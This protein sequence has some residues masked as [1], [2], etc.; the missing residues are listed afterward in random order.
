MNNL[1]VIDFFCGAG[2]FSEGFRQQGFK[3]I[4]GY[5][6][7]KPAIETFN[8]NFD[9]DSE[10]KNILDFQYSIE[11]I[12]K[13]PDTDV[14]IG[15]PP[16]VTFSSSNI[17]G[18]ADKSTGITLTQIFLKIVALKKWK[19]NSKLKAWFMENVPSSI[20]HLGL[21][22]TFED[23]GLAEWAAKNKIGKT[24][25]AIKLE[26]NQLIV[27]SADYG[28]P[29]SRKRAISGEIIK[30]KK[31]IIP[32]KTHGKN[33][34]SKK[35]WVTVEEIKNRIP[36][37]FSKQKSNI[38]QDPSYL[39]L[40]LDQSLLTD[41]Y[42]DTGLYQC[43]WK[44]SKFLKINHPYMGKMSFPENLNR[45]SRTITATKIGT[46]R[47][48]I[49]Y[50]SELSRKGNG[51]FRTPT[52]REAACIMSFPIT[53]QFIGSE[54]VKWRLIGNA[55][56]PT[57]ARA[58]AKELRRQLDVDNINQPLVE[59]KPNL[60]GVNNL[61]SFKLKEYL[62]PPKRNRG[63]RFRRHAFKDGNIT[64]TLSNYNIE[65]NEK[66]ISKW[67]TSVQYGNG[68][69]FPTYNFCDNKFKE[70]EQCLKG[71]PKGKDFIHRIND[72][73]T[74]KIANGKILQEMYEK[75]NSEGCYLEPTILIEEVGN[76]IN[77]MEIEGQK[78]YQNQKTIFLNKNNV[79]LKQVFALYAINKISSVANNK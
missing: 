23:L 8:H 35:K 70:L 72:S 50:K 44:Q 14:I 27:N 40:K 45:P 38:V 28:S 25:V 67:I 24:K 64:V 26:G 73:F 6:N 11:E 33:A 76:I 77:D 54:S 16:C 61:N 30:C 46:S 63:S 75:Q 49:I 51:E 71:I 4:R 53:Y 29:Q 43:E 7:W 60:K 78:F 15:S 47:E 5:D 9:C 10:I 17:S 42:Y 32:P 3:I 39:G 21:E 1:T 55:V 34:I 65:K 74:N 66:K 2:G 58:F 68:K 79:P 41:H 13:L 57:V 36:Q 31:L 12:E 20:K 69:G 48:A 18:K 19:K 59:K 22:Y 52:V 56:C 62:H 37:P